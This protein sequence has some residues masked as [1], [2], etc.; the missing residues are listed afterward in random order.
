MRAWLTAA[1]GVAVVLVLMAGGARRAAAD[2]RWG[3][4]RPTILTL[5]VNDVPRG[6]AL[7]LL[8]P[9]DALVV[10]AELRRVGIQIGGAMTE[11]VR[12]RRFVSLRSL[13]IRFVAAELEMELRLDVAADL[14]PTTTFDLGPPGA[15]AGLTR[16]DQASAYLSY[17]ARLRGQTEAG[18]DRA[19]PDGYVEGGAR[20]AGALLES[21]VTFPASATPVR[22]L[23]DV[24]W[25][26]RRRLRS[27]VLGD[28]PATTGRLGGDLVVGGLHLV[29]AFELDPYVATTPALALDGS[30]LVPSTADVYVDGTLVQRIELP[31]GR[32]DLRNIPVTTGAGTTRVVITDRLGRTREVADTFYA[33]AGLLRPGLSD[34]A[35]SV[36]FRRADLATTSFAYGELV[37]LARYRRG[38][39]R[40]LTAGLHAE[41]SGD[42][43]DGG[44]ELTTGAAFG[45][46]GLELA[47]S[48]DRAG[49]GAAA[50]L[51][52]AY[53]GDRT[54]GALALR[55]ATAG[56]TTLALRTDEPRL[57]ARASLN[58]AL[59][60]KAGLGLQAGAS[61]RPGRAWIGSA[62]AHL[63]TTLADGVALSTTAN[64]AT[65][66]AGG[67][68]WRVL[69]TLSLG[70]GDR[71]RASVTHEQL[72]EAARDRVEL[73]RTVATR[74]VGYRVNAELGARS[75]GGGELEARTRH[76]RYQLGY[77]QTDAGGRYDVTAS[78]GVIALGGRLF[79]T[80]P[81]D[82]SFVLVRV[83]DA[84]GVKVLVENKLVGHTDRRG[85]LLVTGVLPHYGSRIA[86]DPAD[87]P[88]D[89]PPPRTSILLAPPRKGGV[90]ATFPAP[91]LELV[92]GRLV[93][94]RGARRVVPAYGELV[95]GAPP[96]LQDPESEQWR[97]PVGGDGS[98]ELDGVGAGRYQATV[99]WD[100]G[101]CTMTLEVPAPSTSI[102]QLG[103][104]VC[105]AEAP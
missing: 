105:L 95:L 85:E 53:Q 26:D 14:L 60:R 1:A 13:G 4:R 68:E 77:L 51:G 29:R 64:V 20:L 21:S 82:R 67:R 88:E 45:Q 62:A 55:G 73:H 80:E 81:I 18:A 2:G 22:G 15:P 10:D 101:R 83:P 38:L 46:L 47:V 63:G 72:G 31:P 52:W 33:P 7:V 27:F 100:G 34:Y 42:L 11:T 44:V 92:R 36:G 48:G 76:G 16:P 104:R 96:T 28:Q 97:S 8:V 54:G 102:T 94:Q 74:G 58:R 98:F 12:D 40:R 49:T 57:E 103:E 66:E 56:Y 89:R 61:Q 59:T 50:V 69:A 30:V 91:A 79:A 25:D 65:S 35:L 17:A 19:E 32:Y 41:A 99:A 39:G 23:S 86:I 9:G 37:A 87:L 71:T 5:V 75:R 3:N 90:V 84:P 6:E 78:G 43:A 24:R 93:V 70:L